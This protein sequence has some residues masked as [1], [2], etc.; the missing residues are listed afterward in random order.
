MK[1]KMI[2][3]KRDKNILMTLAIEEKNL[4]VSLREFELLNFFS[5]KMYSFIPKN[6][7]EKSDTMSSSLSVPI[8]FSYE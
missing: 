2:V 1:T 8:C 3:I 5:I 6:T 4:I 7:A